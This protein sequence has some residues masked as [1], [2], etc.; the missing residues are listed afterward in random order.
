MTA[1]AEVGL[2]FTRMPIVLEHDW[3]LLQTG[4]KVTWPPMA[5]RRSQAT[6]RFRLP[7]LALFLSISLAIV[8]LH[9]PPEYILPM[10]THLEH[11]SG[12]GL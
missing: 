4:T 9:C 10:H 11:P 12:S 8:A 1:A 7:W 6:T 5:P 3:V 2:K